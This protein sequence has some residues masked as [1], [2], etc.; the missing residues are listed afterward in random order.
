[1]SEKKCSGL[2]GKPCS[3]MSE[4]LHAHRNHNGI[5]AEEKVNDGRSD[6]YLNKRSMSEN[7]TAVCLELL[8]V[9]RNDP[10][11]KAF[12]KPVDWRALGLPSYLQ[13][14]KIQWTSSPSS[15]S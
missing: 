8:M 12:L 11:V 15:L 5:A 14:I 7:L 4:L 10:N 3:G 1:M 2:R 9:I 6:R 13:I